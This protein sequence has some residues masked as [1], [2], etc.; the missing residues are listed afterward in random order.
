MPETSDRDERLAAL[1]A[2]LTRQQ[3]AGQAADIDA[4]A[5]TH[6]DLARELRELWAA[7]QIAEAFV[8]PASATTADY[9]PRGE[10]RNSRPV[11]P[12]PPLPRDFGDY[13]LL[14]ERGRGGMGVV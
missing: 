4:A 12:C 10:D 7:A 14:E 3:R 9:S 13:V 6:P 5:K 2:D 11:A 8:R 1:I